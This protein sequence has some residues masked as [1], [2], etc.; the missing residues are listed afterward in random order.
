MC[1]PSSVLHHRWCYFYGSLDV[2][3]NLE[4]GTESG[5]VQYRS[6]LP[7]LSLPAR[8]AVCGASEVPFL[9]LHLHS[10]SAYFDKGQSRFTAS[11]SVHSA[12]ALGLEINMAHS[13]RS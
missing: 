10:A 5:G 11:S 6:A 2:G 9:P 13:E 1:M 8:V 3:L 4:K 7:F 12:A